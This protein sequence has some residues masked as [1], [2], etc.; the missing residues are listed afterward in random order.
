MPDSPAPID[1][2]PRRYILSLGGWHAEINERGAAVLSLSRG[3]RSRPPLPRVPYGPA[4]DADWRLTELVVVED[5]CGFATLVHVLPPEDGRPELRLQVRYDFSIEGFTTAF[6]V[7]N[8]GGRAGAVELGGT[9][10][11]LYPGDRHVSVS[12][13]SV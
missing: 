12:T 5:D 10:V 7:E 1:A 9:V 11:T 4:A 8:T 3:G 2:V 13:D 6:T